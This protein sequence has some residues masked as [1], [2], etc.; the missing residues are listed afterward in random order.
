MR[1]YEESD[2]ARVDGPYDE[3]AVTVHVVLS[4]GSDKGVGRPVSYRTVQVS[5]K[6]AKIRFF[7]CLAVGRSFVPVRSLVP[8]VVGFE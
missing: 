1:I 2:H 4:N 5:V 7:H 3:I 6:V 8:V